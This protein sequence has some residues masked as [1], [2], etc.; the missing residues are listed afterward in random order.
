MAKSEHS[1]S[2]VNNLQDKLNDMLAVFTI[3]I[4]YLYYRYWNHGEPNDQYSVEDCAAVYPFNNPLKSWNDAPCSHPLKW[5]CEK[6]M[7]SSKIPNPSSQ[8][9]HV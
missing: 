5:I 6:P 7:E 1:D 2:R 3:T 8:T 4:N 9:R